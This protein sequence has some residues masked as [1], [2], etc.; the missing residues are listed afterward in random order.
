[1]LSKACLNFMLHT[2][3]KLSFA[4]CKAA[5]QASL[6]KARI[7][8]LRSASAQK[9]PHPP[10]GVGGGDFKEMPIDLYLG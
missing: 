6:Q 7:L 9:T 1:M 5:K 3:D 10:T 2:S 8:C 4:Q